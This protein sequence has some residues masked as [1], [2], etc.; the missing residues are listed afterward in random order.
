MR[1]Y[2]RY[3]IHAARLLV[4]VLIASIQPK[5]RGVI[6]RFWET[7]LHRTPNGAR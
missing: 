3:A 6:R 4:P 7:G 5:R 1:S 2:T